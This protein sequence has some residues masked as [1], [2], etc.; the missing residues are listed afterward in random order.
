MQFLWDLFDGRS[1][2]DLTPNQDDDGIDERFGNRVRWI[3]EALRKMGREA[4]VTWWSWFYLPFL[5][6]YWVSF[7]NQLHVTFFKGKWG[8]LGYQNINEVYGVTFFYDENPPRPENFSAI[9]RGTE[10]YLSWQ[11]LALNEGGFIIFRSLNGVSF[12]S[13]D[14]TEPEITTF[15]DRNLQ[16]LTTYHYNIN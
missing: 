1:T 12:S 2:P 15:V 16:E 11:D 4:P 8:E 14:T 9:A 5:G 10:A 13:I 7:S 3:G 6:Q